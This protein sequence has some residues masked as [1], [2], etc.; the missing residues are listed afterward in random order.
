MTAGFL[1]L[2]LQVAP[3]SWAP[4]GPD[5]LFEPA[6]LHATFIR[7]IQC[8]EKRA[9][10]FETEARESEQVGTRPLRSMNIKVSRGAWAQG[11]LIC[12]VRL[13]R[14]VNNSESS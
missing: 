9:G 11:S 6:F 3:A 12:H 1:G 4:L 2:W 14:P 10:P 8:F 5:T 13:G 7:R